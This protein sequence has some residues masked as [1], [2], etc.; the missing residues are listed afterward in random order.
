MMDRIRSIKPEQLL[1]ALVIALIGRV[2]V[3][4]VTPDP[5]PLLWRVVVVALLAISILAYWLVRRI[6]K[7]VDVRFDVPQTLESDINRDRYA[8]KG[9]IAFVS[10][11]NPF[12]P[13]GNKPTPKQITDWVADEDYVAL[14]FVNSN[15]ETVI[16]AARSHGA[17]LKYCWLITTE[18]TD[19]R[20]G[21]EPYAPLLAKSMKEQ[22]GIKCK[23]FCGPN[24]VVS[25]DNDLAVTTNTRD[26]LRGIFTEAEKLGLQPKEMVVDITGA[27]RAVTL[28]AVLACL[29]KTR[30]V[31]LVGANY[32]EDGKV[33]PHELTTIIAPF[34]SFPVE[35]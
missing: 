26:L 15:L 14:D 18:H 31:E 13:D 17:A 27:F 21:S 28:G 5:A 24:T 3:F 11:Y 9:L 34:E 4:F 22:H 29:D 6:P 35:T 25:Q 7:P 12:P 19:K 33:I 16:H 32:G 2:V 23:F 1:L 20:R 8:R 10:L 30:D